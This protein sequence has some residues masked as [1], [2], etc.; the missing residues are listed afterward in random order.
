MH[1]APAPFERLSAPT[2][3]FDLHPLPIPPAPQVIAVAVAVSVLDLASR[4]LQGATVQADLDLRDP[5]A[6][7]KDQIVTAMQSAYKIAKVHSEDSA[8][9]FGEPAALQQKY[10]TGLVLDVRTLAWGLDRGIA[11]YKV[12]ARLIR[13][14]NATVI[15]DEI[16]VSSSR[17]MFTLDELTAERGRRV[18]AAVN[19]AAANCAQE[20]SQS[21]VAADEPAPPRD[22]KRTN[23]K[24]PVNEKGV[25]RNALEC[26]VPL[27]RCRGAAGQR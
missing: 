7:V 18:V 21:V 11:R 27:Y 9:E 24:D 13:L 4:K 1:Y 17:A 14:G 25:S 8:A 10:R 19:T 5:A 20:L 6:D 22:T 3:P 15:W 16:C 2:V 12:R 26:E 23:W